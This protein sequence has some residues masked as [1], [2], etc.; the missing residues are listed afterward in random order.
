MLIVRA[1]SAFNILRKCRKRQKDPSE[2][3]NSMD[4]NLKRIICLRLNTCSLTSVNISPVIVFISDTG[5]L[6]FSSLTGHCEP[7]V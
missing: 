1:A 3:R 7:T 6:D 5:E 4:K 2:L